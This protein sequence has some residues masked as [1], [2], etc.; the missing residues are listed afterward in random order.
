MSREIDLSNPGSL[1]VEDRIYLMDRGQLPEGAQPVTQEERDS[2][3]GD[4]SSQDL[5]V[6][7]AGQDPSQE[8]GGQDSVTGESESGGGT[9]DYD[10]LTKDELTDEARRRELSGYSSMTKDELI[11]LLEEDDQSDDGSDAGEG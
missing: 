9:A 10:S 3:E 6:E 2:I 1:S 8:E 7:N 4:G 11:E 5:I